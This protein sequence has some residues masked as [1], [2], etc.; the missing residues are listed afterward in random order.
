MSKAN[1]Q[2]VI[3]KFECL[4]LASDGSGVGYAD[5]LATF[6]QGLLPDEVGTVKVLEKKKTWQRAELLTLDKA[7]PQRNVPP[8]SVYEACGGCRLQHT[9][10][11]ETLAW[12]ARWVED[13]LRRIGKIQVEGKVRPTLGMAEPWRY[14]NKAR[15]HRSQ[16]Q[17]GYYQSKTKEVVPFT[18][19]LLLSERMNQWIAQTKEFL[20]EEYPELETVTFRENPAGEGMLLLEST[21]GIPEFAGLSEEGEVPALPDG[22]VSGQFTDGTSGLFTGNHPQISDLENIGVSSIWGLGSDSHLQALSGG[23]LEVNILGLDFRV[24]PLTFLQVNFAQM[25]VLYSLVLEFAEL[26]G[27]EIVWDLYS[28]IGTLTLALARQAREVWGIEENSYAIQD[29]R[30]NAQRNAIANVRFSAGKVED[31]CAEW[32]TAPDL[33]VLDPPRAGADK[34]VIE[35]FLRLQ[36]ERIIYVSC[37]PGTLARDVG[38]LAEGGYVVERVQPVDMFA[39]TGHVECVIMMTNSGSKGK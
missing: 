17:I 29:A 7:S 20:G 1:S 39:W 4:R 30:E 11:E 35:Q 38:R 24:S 9:T 18:D 36:P 6:V 25:E 22:E 10:Y 12:K 8:C 34:K 2:Q 27:E 3:E 32:Q 14:R 26:T 23:P 33:V 13:A 5:G 21:V 31:L 37:D 28:G 19:C 16:G 15:L